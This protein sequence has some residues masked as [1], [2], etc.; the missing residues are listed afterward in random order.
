ME[1][2]CNAAGLSTARLPTFLLS[3]AFV[4]P[5]RVAFLVAIC[6][7]DCLLVLQWR[8]QAKIRQKPI[9]AYEM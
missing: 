1:V 7:A 3:C 8:K 9:I 2:I 4:L 5:I 6:L